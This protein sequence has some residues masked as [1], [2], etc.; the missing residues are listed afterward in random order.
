MPPPQS[1]PPRLTVRLG[2]LRL[3]GLVA[4]AFLVALMAGL[5]AFIAWQGPQFGPLWISGGLWIAFVL[6]WS[7]AARKSAPTASSES[8]LSRRLHVLATDLGILLGFLHVP[9]LRG[10]W[11]PE[12]WGF[13]VAGLMLQAAG[14][15]LAVWARRHLGR[16]WSGRVETKVGHQLVRSGPYRLI[17]HP[18]YSAML[19]ML[20]GTALVSGHW[21]G[22]AGLA[23]MAG[24]LTRKLRMEE[25]RM[26]EAFGVEWEEWRRHSWSMIP[27]VV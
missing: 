16:N 7:A 19:A 24:A 2:S 11:L 20:A 9:P 8:P 13:V 15:A 3:T 4:V 22:L 23:L 14:F 10:R 12:S 1:P 6:Y 5:V 21:H 25:R 26:R 27:G 18:I 17:R